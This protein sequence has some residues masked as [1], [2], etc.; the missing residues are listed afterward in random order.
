MQ[1]ILI[2]GATSGIG[3]EASVALARDGARVVLAGRDPAKTAATVDQV[4]KRAGVEAVDSVLGDFASQASIRQM[5]N[6][7][8]ARYDRLDVLVNNAGAVN[9]S[10]TVTADGI[11][12]TFAVNHLGPF[13]FTNLLL[14]LLKSS[15]PARIV[16]V[17]SGAHY[18]ATLDF[19]DLGYE[20][21]GYRIMRAYARSKLGNVLFT[22]SLASR[23]EGTGVTANAL[24]PGG[25]ATN[26]WSGAPRAAKP[27]LALY[28]RF[29][30]IS[31]EKGAETITY[32][33]V[34]PQVEGKTGLY[35]EKNQ[36]KEPSKLAQ[37]DAVAQQLWDESARLVRL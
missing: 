28:K 32:L 22:R 26:I 10:R 15:A 14:D 7:V 36:A 30:M 21:G 8:L 34:S 24:H 19:D 4:R 29:G 31:P 18:M 27:L 23:L 13:L 6:D 25:V 17:S 11:E 12:A 37:D 35:F 16:N 2:T 33:A 1:T 20:R 3:L 5:A 9:A